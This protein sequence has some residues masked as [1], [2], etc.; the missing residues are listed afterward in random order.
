GGAARGARHW[1][2][3]GA[4]PARRPA[5][6]GAGAAGPAAPRLSALAADGE[7]LAVCS[8]GK[9]IPGALEHLTGTAEDFTTPK[10]GGWLLAFTG[11]RLLA[12]DRL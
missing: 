11:D 2:G 3:G 10:G 5:P 6:P 7:P 12:A 9:V 1:G 8:Q 4:G